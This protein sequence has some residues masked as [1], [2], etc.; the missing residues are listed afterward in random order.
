MSLCMPL[1]LAA[2]MTPQNNESVNDLQCD[3]RGGGF[4]FLSILVV[5]IPCPII[6]GSKNI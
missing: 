2:R 6:W 1:G 3:G 4:A 5:S